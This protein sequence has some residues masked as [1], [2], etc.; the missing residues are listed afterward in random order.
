MG[1]PVASK[2][3]YGFGD[4]DVDDLQRKAFPPMIVID[5]IDDRDNLEAVPSSTDDE[6]ESH[7]RTIPRCKDND[8]ALDQFASE[9]REAIK[10]QSTN[11]RSL[12][13][14]DAFES[15]FET[16]A[17]N[18][19]SVADS[20]PTFH[21]RSSL[22]M[23]FGSES[24]DEDD[25]EGVDGGSIASTPVK[26]AQFLSNR[27]LRRTSS[28]NTIDHIGRRVL[29]ANDQGNKV[30]TSMQFNVCDA[31]RTAVSATPPPTNMLPM[32]PSTPPEVI[33]KGRLRGLPPIRRFHTPERWQR[34]LRPQQYS[35]SPRGNQQQKRNRKALP[36][37]SFSP[38]PKTSVEFSGGS[39]HPTLPRMGSSCSINSTSGHHRH[40]SS[41]TS[42]SHHRMASSSSISADGFRISSG[43]QTNKN[44]PAKDP[45]FVRV[46]FVA[47]RQGQLGLVL[48]EKSS[49]SGTHVIAV[50]D[51]SPLFGMIM[52]GDR[53]LEIDGK[54]VA[55]ATLTEITKLMKASA[56]PFPFVYPRAAMNGGTIVINPHHNLRIAVLRRPSPAVIVADTD[57]KRHDSLGSGSGGSL[58]G[59]T[60]ID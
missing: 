27:P 5:N 8:R 48:G 51:Y 41:S 14:P 44:I 54:N 22:D 42:S 24:S 16:I 43:E 29:S 49:C 10:T 60:I 23:L 26:S 56:K 12:V 57:H 7:S 28:F 30:D 3:H 37:I 58:I 25:D 52:K 31:P 50:K 4:S 11:S 40:N 15:F 36:M 38:M 21:S 47:P 32:S 33:E 18:E 17:P 2:M 6:I 13:F 19:S 39:K 9:F 46:E 45:D 35:H 20:K 59:S 34:E 55:H 1:G 53:M